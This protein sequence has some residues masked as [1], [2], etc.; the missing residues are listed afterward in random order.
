MGFSVR[1][2][3]IVGSPEP[4]RRGVFWGL[5][6]FSSGVAHRASLWASRQRGAG[7]GA[8]RLW[9]SGEEA[10]SRLH[11]GLVLRV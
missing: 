7:V 5:R 10:P 6:P 8:L 1:G 3:V 11:I 9:K 2:L 4:L